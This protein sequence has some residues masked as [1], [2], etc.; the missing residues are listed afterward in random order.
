MRAHRTAPCAPLRY[1]LP[2]DY[3]SA[4]QAAYFHR[5]HQ[6]MST[7]S[8]TWIQSELGIL[9]VVF[10]W[11]PP[12]QAPRMDRPDGPEPSEYSQLCT[13]IL[14]RTGRLAA[15]ALNLSLAADAAGQSTKQAEFDPDAEVLTLRTE[16]WQATV[17]VQVGLSRARLLT[18]ADG[19]LKP[20]TAFP[21]ELHVLV[22]DTA[23]A[24]AAAAAGQRP[25]GPMDEYVYMF[26]QDV[27][28]G[29]C[30]AAGTAPGHSEAV[31]KAV[32]VTVSSAVD[33]APSLQ[34]Q[35][36]GQVP[37][38]TT[39]ATASSRAG[40]VDLISSDSDDEQLRSILPA[41]RGRS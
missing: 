26:R 9:P 29:A 23:A 28:G 6:L 22:Q 24:A 21:A 27:A 25:A 31:A 19:K 7:R 1:H 11:L 10:T 41:K 40:L 32:G 3:A 5:A 17:T 12:L 16:H 30:S 2:A 8:R 36:A 38:Q 18:P 35:P 15:A 20:G 34:V 33:H 13:Q 14:S 4:D 39:A 37:A